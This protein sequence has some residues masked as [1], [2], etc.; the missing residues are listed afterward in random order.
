MLLSTVTAE[1]ATAVTTEIALI[2][3]FTYFCF[4]TGRALPVLEIE[5]VSKVF[6]MYE[7]LDLFLVLESLL[8][9]LVPMN[10]MSL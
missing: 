6:T 7:T 10:I 8:C 3:I 2:R 9:F 4:P 1:V 5:A